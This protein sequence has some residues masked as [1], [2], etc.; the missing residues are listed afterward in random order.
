M[1]IRATSN[2]PL[3]HHPFTPGVIRRCFG[4]EPQAHP[5]ARLCIAPSPP[6]SPACD[7]PQESAS[8]LYE[9]PAPIRG[10]RHQDAP[11]GGAGTEK[12]RVD[13]KHT[14]WPLF[15]DFLTGTIVL[16]HSRA[17]HTSKPLSQC[18]CISHVGYSAS[19]R[20]GTAVIQRPRGGD[21]TLYHVA[22]PATVQHIPNTSSQRLKPPLVRT[23]IVRVSQ[24]M[25]F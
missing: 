21:V 6:H 7:H 4:S 2:P 1:T 18:C 15:R 16:P 25:G 23:G 8:H 12:G 9:K 24:C 3:R 22:L 19:G 10:I 14:V 17:V 20:R 13:V 11:H 5:L